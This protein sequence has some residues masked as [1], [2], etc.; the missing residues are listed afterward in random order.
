MLVKNELDVGNIEEERKLIKTGSFMVT[1]YT[2]G[3]I[4]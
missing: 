2:A 1:V 3:M 4:R